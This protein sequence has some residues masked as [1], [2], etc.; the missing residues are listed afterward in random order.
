M[1][2]PTTER[3]WLRFPNTLKAEV[4]TKVSSLT[5]VSV[6]FG[7]QSKNNDKCVVVLTVV[8]PHVSVAETETHTIQNLLSSPLNMNSDMKLKKPPFYH[9]LSERKG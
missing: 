6:S 7:V 4:S 2:Y 9:P 5:S 1:H 8:G 3:F